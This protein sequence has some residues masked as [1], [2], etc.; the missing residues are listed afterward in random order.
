[1][2]AKSPAEL[3][4]RIQALEAR[5]RSGP[6]HVNDLAPLLALC[7]PSRGDEPTVAL[8]ALHAL[9]R[10]FTHL[11]AYAP[12]PTENDA[13]G[14]AAT[15]EGD[16]AAAGADPELVYKSW[17]RARYTTFLKRLAGQ[18]LPDA[19]PV[20]QVA[21]LRTLMQFA[22]REPP[23]HH[24]TFN[25]VLRQMVSGANRQLLDGSGHLLET[26]LSEFADT[27]PDV[28][29][30]AWAGLVKVVE[31]KLGFYEK[32]QA[33]AAAA[34]DELG[35]AEN[36]AGAGAAPAGGTAAGDEVV[37]GAYLRAM[38]TNVFEVLC[39]LRPPSDSDAEDSDD[40]GGALSSDSSDE[41]EVRIGGGK[42]K[43]FK[44]KKR[45]RGGGR[46]GKKKKKKGG[47]NMF[48]PHGEAP[49]LRHFAKAW[50]AFLKLPMSAPTYRRVLRKLAE[51]V[52]PC[53]PPMLVPQL[54]DFYTDAY[55][56]GGAI[57]LMALH[58]L[59][60]L[61]T[62]HNV[63]YPDFYAKLYA[64]LHVDAFHAKHRAK[65]F[66]L[67]DTFLGSTHLPAYLVCAFCKKLAR[68]ALSAPPAGPLFA[69]PFVYN[70]IK[71]HPAAM[72][73]IHRPRPAA[74]DGAG[75]VA[76]TEDPFDPDEDDPAR[77]GA[78]ES[79]LWEVLALRTHYLPAVSSLAAVFEKEFAAPQYPIEK[80]GFTAVTYA[81]LFDREVTSGRGPRGGDKDD[82]GGRDANLKGGRFGRGKKKSKRKKRAMPLAFEK[83]V[84]LFGSVVQGGQQE[85][86]LFAL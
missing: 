52:M 7:D 54:A 36:G 12:L 44:D 46:G 69:L 3:K 34:D 81:S 74:Y 16:A 55:N 65:F 77:C 1:M 31:G 22:A 27:Y 85:E 2:A 53:M 67:L 23:P 61:M 64:L 66:A 35:A 59:F 25:L 33:E 63:D 17:V 8:S 5:V 41:E 50:L 73:L 11:E 80:G 76:A 39:G 47:P 19:R 28:R 4:E 21:A 56:Q 24:A 6:E 70:M 40:D 26:F 32:Q 42:H 38:S 20:V 18:W 49:E 78:L 60:L 14:D 13:A 10:S 51:D 15:T 71:R 9:R 62:R 57:A 43:R 83:P 58:G 82:A 86:D 29:Q 72:V 84:G 75:G 79:S 37:D 30:L 45:K 68:L 48:F